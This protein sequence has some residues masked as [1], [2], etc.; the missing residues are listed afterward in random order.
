M[1]FQKSVKKEA[2]YYSSSIVLCP[3]I[4]FFCILELQ[5]L[6]CLENACESKF[7]LIAWCGR[8]G[9]GRGGRGGE[10]GNKAEILGTFS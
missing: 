3:C 1:K 9:W 2:L 5:T 7:S 10:E 6:K 8:W 4:F